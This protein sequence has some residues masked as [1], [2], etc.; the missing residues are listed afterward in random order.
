MKSNL[1]NGILA[2]LILLFSANS[3]AQENKKAEDV[4]A[5]KSMC[6]C[7]EIEFNF[8]E[9]FR[10]T[11]DE[12]Y[13]P[14]KTKKEYGLEW[15]E[16][17][18]EQPN[19]FVL[20]HLLIVDTMIVKHWRQDWEYESAKSYQFY[21]D[22]TWKFQSLDPKDVK[23]KWTQKVYQVDDSPRYSGTATW[24]HVDGK[25]YWTSTTDAPLPRREYTIRKDYNVLNRTNTQE[26]TATGWIHDQDNIK[27]LRD[28]NG[29]DKILAKEKGTDYYTKVADSRCK[30]S[31]DYWKKTAVMWKNVRAKW[32]AIYAQNKDLNME[33]KIDD[34]T[35]YEFL[36]NLKP[37]ATKAETDKI[38]DSFV[39]K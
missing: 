36:F 31:Q 20:Q 10:Y 21:K 3:N 26:I 22:K 19:R 8:A 23:G 33:T 5:I 27:I 18:E 4:K 15:V 2:A 34:K 29:K 9:T 16:L 24:V 32:D 17:V 38:I 28:E 14:S 39:K 7:F 25:H 11:K 30:A 12:N 37:T 35:L 6:G 13:V 1:T